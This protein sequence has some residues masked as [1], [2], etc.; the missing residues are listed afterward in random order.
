[1]DWDNYLLK[2][3]K[4]EEGLTVKGCLQ[5]KHSYRKARNGDCVHFSVIFVIKGTY[6]RGEHE[7]KIKQISPC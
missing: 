6:R 3:L 4:T 7:E 1:M 2:V 5:G